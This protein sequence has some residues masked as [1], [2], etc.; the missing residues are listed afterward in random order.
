V[1]LSK[2]EGLAIIHERGG[3]GRAFWE[4]VVNGFYDIFVKAS[5][6]WHDSAHFYLVADL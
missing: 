5:E 2:L 3:V 6:K 4:E 1:R